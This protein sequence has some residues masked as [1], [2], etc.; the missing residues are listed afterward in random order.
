M[1]KTRKGI[2]FQMREDGAGNWFPL[3][4][5][6]VGSSD[7]AAMAV[8]KSVTGF[9]LD[10]TKTVVQLQTDLIAAVNAQEGT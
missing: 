6:T 1:A 7:D 10:T 5:C 3:I 2:L 8:G 4:Q 9:V